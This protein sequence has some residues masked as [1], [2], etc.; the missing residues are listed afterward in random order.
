MRAEFQAFPCGL[1]RYRPSLSAIPWCRKLVVFGKALAV[2]K[3]SFHYGHP[4]WNSQAIVA[5]SCSFALE[6]WILEKG[7][8]LSEEFDVFARLMDVLLAHF[9]PCNVFR[10][11]FAFRKVRHDLSYLPHCRFTTVAAL[12]PALFVCKI[13]VRTEMRHVFP[14]LSFPSPLPHFLLRSLKLCLSFSP[15]LIHIFWTNGVGLLKWIKLSIGRPKD[16]K[17]DDCL[18]ARGWAHSSAWSRK[19]LGVVRKFNVVR[20]CK[21]A[22]WPRLA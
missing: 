12:D 2:R 16:K 4:S 5:A 10:Q 13:N 6:F 7:K 8:L 19:R 1:F 20:T 22:S 3:M 15:H 11:M 18:I 21:P 14:D 17:N 9:R